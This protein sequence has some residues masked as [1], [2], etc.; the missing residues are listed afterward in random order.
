VRPFVP[1]LV[2]ATS[3]ACGHVTP[4]YRT[5]PE[6]IQTIYIAMPEND[7]MEYGFQEDLARHLNE[8]FLADGRVQPVNAQRAD[9]RLE[10]SIHHFSR[11]VENLN[12]DDFPLTD[13]VEVMAQIKLIEPHQDEPLIQTNV[14]ATVFFLSDP[15]RSQFVQE[16]EWRD[17]L[18]ENLAISIMNAV[19]SSPPGQMRVETAPTFQGPESFQG[20][21]LDLDRD[22]DRTRQS[23]GRSGSHF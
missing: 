17:Q 11:D 19:I 4:P 9:A 5:L 8:E 13:S 2:A 16:P 12:D 3:L 10:T 21:D 15:R 6:H 20:Q 18:M 1:L 7:S 22:F 23:I 14:E